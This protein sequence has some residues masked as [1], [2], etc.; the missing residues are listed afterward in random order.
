LDNEA[1]FEHA[2]NNKDIFQEHWHAVRTYL[3]D[4]KTRLLVLTDSDD[5][6]HKEAVQLARELGEKKKF[7]A[8]PTPTARS[9][10][11]SYPTPTSRTA[12]LTETVTSEV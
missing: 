5:P 6:F 8:T 4:K 7:A 2:L 12:T 9:T 10:P 1:I 11:I 3:L